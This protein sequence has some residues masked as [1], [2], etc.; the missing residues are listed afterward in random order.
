MFKDA[1]ILTKSYMQGGFC[2]AGIDVKTGKWI[3]FVR[4]EKGSSMPYSFP[5]NPLDVVRVEIDRYNPVRNHTEDYIVKALKLISR[6]SLNDVINIHAPENHG[7]IFGNSSTTL[8]EQEM[9]M[10][11]FDYSLIF[12]RV[13]GMHIYQRKRSNKY[14]AYFDYNG[15][16]YK[17]LRITDPIYNPKLGDLYFENAYIVVSMPKD[18]F[19]DGLYYKF[20]A[21]IFPLA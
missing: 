7:F 9:Q 21:K 16:Y 10:F 8:S 6:V 18:S 19:R 20:V 17:N 11:N 15:V 12:I 14:V 13:E 3:R 5:Y 1:V 2:V 4:D